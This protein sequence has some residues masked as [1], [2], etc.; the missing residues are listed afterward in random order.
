M[1]SASQAG[2]ISFCCGDC[3]SP[4]ALQWRMPRGAGPDSLVEERMRAKWR[5][6]LNYGIVLGK[7][8]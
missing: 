6:I 7:A 2:A 4:L 3:P 8:I 5:L 1:A